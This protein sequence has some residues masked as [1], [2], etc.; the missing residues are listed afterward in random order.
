MRV[1]WG[2]L[3]AARLWLQGGWSLDLW[4]GAEG[5]RE[6]SWDF[7]P[8]FLALFSS[9]CHVRLLL[10]LFP[11]VPQTLW[12]SRL[13]HQSS[14]WT[15]V[16]DLW[17]PGQQRTLDLRRKTPGPALPTADFGLVFMPDN[18]SPGHRAQLQ[19][20]VKAMGCVTTTTHTHT[21]CGC[22]WGPVIESLL[23]FPIAALQDIFYHPFK[24]EERDLWGPEVARHHTNR[25]A[26]VLLG[27]CSFHT[28]WTTWGS[29]WVGTSCALLTLMPSQGCPSLLPSRAEQH[30]LATPV[31]QDSLDLSSRRMVTI[32]VVLLHPKEGHS[33]QEA[34]GGGVTG[35]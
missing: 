23:S 32:P 16:R 2:H 19:D 21:G 14:L 4:W 20:P 5:G 33:R 13:T 17:C 35:P 29:A 6:S 27:Q 31:E 3:V 7:L 18:L 24:G 22:L 9:T 1:R 10:S 25:A 15:Q 8:H 26:F 12:N 34:Q 28:D 11:P 30:T